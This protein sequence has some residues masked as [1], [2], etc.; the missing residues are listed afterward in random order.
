LLTFG[1][2]N[3]ALNFAISVVNSGFFGEGA[4][5]WAA[6]EPVGVVWQADS[7]SAAHRALNFKQV[8]RIIS[9][10]AWCCCHTLHSLGFMQRTLQSWRVTP[11]RR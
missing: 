4:S 8:F 1:F 9:P 5:S 6:L 11:L 3:W 7:N 2:G 10:K